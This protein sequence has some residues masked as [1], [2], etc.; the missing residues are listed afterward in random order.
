LPPSLH[1][2]R[3]NPK[4]DFAN[5]PFYVQKRLAQWK[6][7]DGPRRAGVSSFG[8]G[9]T[10]AHV[11]LEEAPEPNASDPS[12]GGALLLPLSA[13]TEQA[14]EAATANLCAHLKRNPALNLAD[15]AYT[16]QVGRRAFNHRRTLVCR[17]VDEA[18]SAL[19]T[20]DRKRAATGVRKNSAPTVAFMFPGQGAQHAGMTRELYQSEQTFR[21]QVD[22]CAERIAPDIGLD[23][24]ET[25]YAGTL[26]A[27][28]AS[29]RLEQT[30]ITQPALFIVEYALAK[31]WMKWGV[32]PAAMI[33]HSIGEYVAA[34]LAGVLTLEDALSL[35]TLRGR[36]M[37]QLPRGAMLSVA[38]GET[39][40]RM[41]LDA[42][43]SIA[44]VNG[45]E[46]CVVAGAL[47]AIE[48]LSHGL[49]AKNIHCKLLRTSHA[50]HSQMVEPVLTPFLQHVRGLRLMPPQIPFVSNV[51]GKWMTDAEATDPHYWSRHLRQTV[52]FA[53]GAQELL[54]Q[55]ELILLE[56]GP[57]QTLCTLV[58]QLALKAAGR[59]VLA[60]LA[61]PGPQPPDDASMLKTLGQLWLEGVQVNWPALHSGETR[62]RIPLPAYPFERKRYWVARSYG[63][64][65]ERTTREDETAAAT[66]VETIAGPDLISPAQ[67][68]SS[69]ARPFAA[70]GLRD[71]GRR[72]G[73]PE[74]RH[75]FDPR[76]ES[77]VETEQ[78]IAQQL[79][80]MA[81]Q[82]DVLRDCGLPVESCAATEIPVSLKPEEPAESSSRVN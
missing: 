55:P 27:L 59:S 13:K 14:L 26:E 71:R 47:E 51:T 76:R 79:R 43:L 66:S 39:E 44:A 9:G 15:V 46:R 25:L 70:A 20:S 32:K 21:E 73:E 72:A 64:T 80:V 35:V 16:L 33:G 7:D 52:R 65:S 77:A 23:L 48:E 24:R 5:S 4:I 38:L 61:Q 28:E 53:E 45:P 57:G 30:F 6:T 54:K 68:P 36:L 74:T 8:I 62:R 17:D 22:Y 63:Q 41:M 18:I 78:I 42:R 56:V 2:T 10:N 50:F 12:D 58:G 60:S 3:P 69:P 29:Q 1:F 49:A 67:L 19:E 40:L 11:I 75:L 81:A 31:L 82:L 34:C 37:Q